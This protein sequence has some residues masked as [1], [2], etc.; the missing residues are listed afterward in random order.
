MS[1][2]VNIKTRKRKVIDIFTEQFKKGA[3]SLKF[4]R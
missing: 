4:V 1:L 3:E 2:S